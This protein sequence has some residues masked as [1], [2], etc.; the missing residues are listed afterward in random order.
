[1]GKILF[2]ITVALAS[3]MLV[4]SLTCNQ[5]N[6]GLAGYCLSNTEVACSNSTHV[7]FSAKAT[8]PAVSDTN[9]FNT[10]GCRETSGCNV[11]GSGTLLGITYET[12]LNCCE[13]DKCNTVQLSG[14]PSTKMTLTATIAAAILA[15][16]CG[17]LL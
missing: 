4:E 2:G 11:T 3:L 8:F 15:S 12:Q 1:M 6:Y 13:T 14:A 10:L 5:C 17:S 9:G 16:M 7:C